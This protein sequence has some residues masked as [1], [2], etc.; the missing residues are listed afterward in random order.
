MAISIVV[1]LGI[2][3]LALDLAHGFQ[4]KALAQ[5]ALDA[6]ALAGAKAVSEGLPLTG[7]PPNDATSQATSVFASQ[8]PAGS[9]FHGIVPQVE[10]SVNLNPFTPGA[11]IPTARFVRV[12]LVA[13]QVPMTV[14]LARVVPGVASTLAIVGSAVAG[15]QAINTN[16]GAQVCD[17]APVTICE[18]TPVPTDPTPTN[19]ADD[20]RC[21]GF[22][23]GMN[24]TVTPN[25]PYTIGTGS[26]SNVNICVKG[27]PSGNPNQ[28]SDCGS[29]LT[30][31]NMGFLNM[32]C[33]SSGGGANCL[34]GLLAG[35]SGSTSCANLNGSCIPAQTGNIA[36]AGHGYNTRFGQGVSNP[37]TNT[38]VYPPDVVTTANPGNYWVTN[39]RTDVQNGN[40]TTGF[41]PVPV[42]LGV[43]GRRFLAMPI[44]AKNSSICPGGSG[45]GNACATVVG[46]ACVFATAPIGTGNNSVIR[47]QMIGAKSLIDNTVA[48]DMTPCKLLGA[49]S[50]TPT[51]PGPGTNNRI[52]LYNDPNSPDS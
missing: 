22:P 21:F 35:D 48:G 44:A 5:N 32:T 24:T 39:Y 12:K 15:P 50:P 34:E 38:A 25:V 43:E 42:G 46:M 17:V 20:Q 3:G 47:I 8:F 1:L 27:S 26:N 31:A 2:A 36:S 45:G 13:G 52:V 51:P 40:Y 30:N 23:G 7:A 14:F 9:P 10:F 49:P 4:M 29:F 11:T 16:S 18:Q 19:C 28:P 6:A 37:Y 41:E 33:P